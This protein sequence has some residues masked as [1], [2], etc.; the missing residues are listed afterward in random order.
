MWANLLYSPAHTKQ[1]VFYF[2]II[3]IKTTSEVI[4]GYF[5]SLR[6]VKSHDHIDLCNFFFY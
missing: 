3:E 2:I 4:G 5:L 6:K 1:V